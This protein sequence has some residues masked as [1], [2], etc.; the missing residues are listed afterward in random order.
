VTVASTEWVL[1]YV[2]SPEYPLSA[3]AQQLFDSRFAI[4]QGHGVFE[5]AK[6]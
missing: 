6:F 1:L 2:E 5:S 4:C 3:L